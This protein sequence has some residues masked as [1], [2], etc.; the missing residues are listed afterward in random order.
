M[1]ST[2]QGHGSS[3]STFLAKEIDERMSEPLPEELAVLSGLERFAFRLTRRMNEGRVKRFWTW[4]Q[5]TFGAGWIHL[6]TYNLMRVYGLENVEAVD[7]TR[8]ILLVANHR[9]YFDMYTVSTVLFRKTR[10]RKQLFFPVRGR[11]FYDSLFGIFVNFIMGWWSMF[12]PF[13]SGGENPLIEKR[14]FDKY[15]MRLLTELSTRGAGNVVGFHP[16]GMRNRNSDPYS[17]LRAQPGVGKLVKDAQ[18]QVIPVFIAG[19]GNDLRKQVLGNWRGGQ[20][21]R[22]RFGE[23]LDIS[24]F[25][26]RRDSVRT[27]KEIAD[28][29]MS[30]IAELGEADRLQFA[31]N[32]EE[33]GTSEKVLT[34]NTSSETRVN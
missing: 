13:F 23:Q 31:K 1:S 20:P 17:F 33:G 10:W 9:S 18:P 15:S 28:F 29:L 4:C 3:R 32:L 2:E 11:F 14:E 12:P 6:S 5:K 22:I 27:Y 25:A 16:E 34:E 26:A 19:L 24:S 21:I 8:P 30:K 7:H